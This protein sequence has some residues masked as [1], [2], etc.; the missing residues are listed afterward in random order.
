[1]SR[2]IKIS[3]AAAMAVVVAG[4]GVAVAA[5]LVSGSGSGSA[6][7]GSLGTLTVNS[8]TASADLYPGGSGKLFL[9]VTSGS[10]IPLKITGVT[11][12]GAI[13]SD[14]VECAGTNVTFANQTGLNIPI[15]ANATNYAFDLPSAVTMIADAADA[16]QGATFTIPVTV[17][18]ETP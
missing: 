1:M 3:V 4:A 9:K 7:A 16:C 12:T 17:N 2:R 15:A 10:T 18:A 14:D 8:A 6:K 13:T 5:W 11:G